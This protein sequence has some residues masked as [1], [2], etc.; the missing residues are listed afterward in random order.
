MQ[1]SATATAP[2]QPIVQASIGEWLPTT[3]SGA[4]TSDIGLSK[5]GAACHQRPSINEQRTQGYEAFANT[6][7]CREDSRTW[8]ADGTAAGYCPTCPH[9]HRQVGTPLLDREQP[10]ARV[11]NGEMGDEIWQSSPP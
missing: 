11:F 1:A 7:S 10:A 9:R 5:G 4:V 8:Q 3:V 2:A 6:I